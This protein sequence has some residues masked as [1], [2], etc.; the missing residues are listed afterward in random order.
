MDANPHL[1]R[2]SV[3]FRQFHELEN[4]RTAVNE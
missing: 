2:A 1:P 3:N 4:F